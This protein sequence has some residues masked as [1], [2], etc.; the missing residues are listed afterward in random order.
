MTTMTA[1]LSGMV[2]VSGDSDIEPLGYV[3]WFSVPDR[4]ANL[5][6]LHYEW[7]LAKLDEKQLPDVPR[8]LYLFKRAC[9]EQKGKVRHEDGTVT[10]TDVRL[11]SEDHDLC[12][13]QISRVVRDKAQRVVNYPKAMRVTFDKSIATDPKPYGFEPLDE[14]PTGELLPMMEAISDYYDVAGKQIDGRKVRAL[15]R[16]YLR[17]DPDPQREL[18][19]LSGLNLRGKAGGVYFIAAKHKPVLDS[20]AQVLTGLYK[21]GSAYLY[22]VPLAD[23]ASERELVRRHHVNASLEE[24]K[25]AMA[26][27]ADIL[28]DRTTPVRADVAQHHWRRLQLLR[29]RGQEYAELLNDEQTEVNDAMD[30]LKKQLDRLV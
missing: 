25:E 9:S 19:G 2:A 1:P 24:A 27:V 7:K 28:R 15:V 26:E 4:P 10:E 3:T 16:D 8:P 11:V 30:L 18:P 20:L 5:R 12:I 22:T 21:D 13:Y 17:S 6:R 14:V 23:G 29:E